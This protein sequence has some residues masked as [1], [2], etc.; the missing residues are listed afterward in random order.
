MSWDLYQRKKGFQFY[1]VVQNCV[2]QVHV[3]Q[4]YSM[5]KK[6][7]LGQ[8]VLDNFANTSPAV[9]NGSL[10]LVPVHDVS[11]NVITWE[12][13]YICVL[14]SISMWYILV[15]WSVNDFP[16]KLAYN[17]FPP[18]VHEDAICF[19]VLFSARKTKQSVQEALDPIDLRWHM[20]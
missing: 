6:D 19:T 3:S 15:P 13:T 8:I 16:Q 5:S 2:Y 11:S 14:V 17:G 10:R 9:I 12:W 1:T 7:L 4:D 18:R 20:H